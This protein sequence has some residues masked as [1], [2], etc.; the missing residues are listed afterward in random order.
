MN[1]DTNEKC[2][3]C[4][5]TLKGAYCHHCG[6][7]QESKLIPLSA[8]IQRTFSEYFSLDNQFLATVKKLLL[9]PGLLTVAWVEGKRQKYTPPVR[10]YIIISLVY[11]TVLALT[12]SSSFFTIMNFDYETGAVY[13]KW[14]PR[15]MFLMMPLFAA[16]LHLVHIKQK[17]YYVEHL[18][19]SIHIYCIIFIISAIQSALRYSIGAQ[20]DV[21]FANLPIWYRIIDM[22]LGIGPFLYLGLSLKRVYQQQTW[23][24]VL[25][26]FALFIL[27]LGILILSA[28]IIQGLS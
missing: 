13:R 27:F 2:L 17:K 23:L 8:F 15:M 5:S 4:G 12:E 21:T 7:K 20:A 3:N 11:F 22:I 28:L 24:V 16:C 1:Q 14:L 18:I 6:Q 9:K 25:K 19:F 26:T 10:L